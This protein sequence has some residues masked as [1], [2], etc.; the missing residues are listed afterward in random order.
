VA[1]PLQRNVV[2]VVK[3]IRRVAIDMRITRH[4]SDR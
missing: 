4:L 2:N 1:L 3:E